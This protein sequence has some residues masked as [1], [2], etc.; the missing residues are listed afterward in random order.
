M[1]DKVE[2]NY[3]YHFIYHEKKEYYFDVI[4][5][6]NLQE[7]EDRLEI[8]RDFVNM[9][10]P[11]ILDLPMIRCEDIG[12]LLEVQKMFK[13]EGHK[14]VLYYYAHNIPTNDSLTRPFNTVIFRRRTEG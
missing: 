9:N 6:Q 4:D 12:E 8:T 3:V 11:D 2:G 13:K 7:Y 5:L 10:R 14:G 1:R